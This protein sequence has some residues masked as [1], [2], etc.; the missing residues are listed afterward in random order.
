[1]VNGRFRP[2]AAIGVSGVR[3]PPEPAGHLPQNAATTEDLSLSTLPGL[4]SN[5]ITS[6]SGASLAKHALTDSTVIE[7]EE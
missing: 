5:S 2:E 1:M 3:R 7:L 6:T 4:T